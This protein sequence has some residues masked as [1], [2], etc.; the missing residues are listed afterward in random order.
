MRLLI[1]FLLLT[2]ATFS[3]GWLPAGGRSMSMANATVSSADEWS[4][5]NNPGATACAKNFSIGISYENRFLLKELQTQNVA[6]M[7]PLKVGVISIGGHMY[8]YQN[9]RSIKGGVGYSLPLVENL[10]AG[11]QLNYQGIQLASNYGSK[12]SMTAEAGL[13]YKVSDNWNFGLSVF[14]LGRSKL[15][16]YQDDRFTTIMRLG[17][18]YLFSEKLLVSAEVD[19]DLEFNPRFRGGIE[20]QLVD[21]LYLRGGFATGR[22]EYTFGMGC[23]IKIINLNFG[24]SYD[25]ILGW[26]PHFSISYIADKK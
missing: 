26:S 20:Y 24:S 17:T 18:S 25:Q 10:F 14:N 4:Y 9:F 11:V 2:T 23:Q 6:I 21:G 19:K 12:N 3:Q 13:Y 22:M 7:V 1:I 5:F 16:E 8:G 15:S